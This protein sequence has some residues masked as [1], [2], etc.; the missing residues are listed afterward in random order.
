MH[1]SSLLQPVASIGSILKYKYILFRSRKEIIDYMKGQ[2]LQR[3]VWVKLSQ[4]K[5]SSHEGLDV[6]LNRL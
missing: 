2:N 4:T 1:S 6:P 5:P 3:Q